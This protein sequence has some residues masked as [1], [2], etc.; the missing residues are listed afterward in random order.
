M[1]AS[2]DHS[3]YPKAILRLGVGGGTLYGFDIV[4][5]HRQAASARGRILR[6][7]RGASRRRGDSALLGFGVVTHEHP[8][9]HGIRSQ[10]LRILDLAELNGVDGHA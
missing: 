2:V 7:R 9:A 6:G 5:R 10:L 4:S 8:L 1:D 3:G